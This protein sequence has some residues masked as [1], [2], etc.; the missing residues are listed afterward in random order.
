MTIYFIIMQVCSVLF[1]SL[2]VRDIIFLNNKHVICMVCVCV[3]THHN[4]LLQISG[5]I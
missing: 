4:N 3:P 5:D 1:C 2:S